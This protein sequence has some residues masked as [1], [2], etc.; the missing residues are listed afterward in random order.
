MKDVRH[1][2]L[3]VLHALMLLERDERGSVTIIVALILDDG[4]K[5]THFA[6]LRA[7]MSDGFV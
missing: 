2:N 1:A 5:K 7:L 3:I 4:C 6:A